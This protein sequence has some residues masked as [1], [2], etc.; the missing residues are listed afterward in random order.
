M[1]VWLGISEKFPQKAVFSAQTGP[2]SP[3][4]A[5]SPAPPGANCRTPTA[6]AT[7]SQPRPA[8]GFATDRIGKPSRRQSAVAACER[9]S[10]GGE[11]T[12]Q[13]KK[14]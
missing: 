4:P 5:D 6:A 11:Q 9:R 2:S 10:I 12:Y 13:H 7:A 1:Q 14:R 8:A 3:G